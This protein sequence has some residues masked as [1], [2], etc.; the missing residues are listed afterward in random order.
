MNIKYGE[1]LL[2]KPVIRSVT[3]FTYKPTTFDLEEVVESLKMAQGILLL[4]EKKLKELGYDVFTTRISLP[5]LPVLLIKRLLDRIDIPD[6]V[7]LSVGG[8]DITHIDYDLA[9]DIVSR[10]Y[11]F[12]IYGISRN[13]QEYSYTI[14]RLI[15][16]IA[17]ENPVYATQ[18][19]I[20]YHHTP[21]E[22]PYF[23][24]S[25]S[26]GELG[27]GFSFLYPNIVKNILEETESL[28]YTI[29]KLENMFRKTI[30]DI[31]HLG[32]GKYRFGID[33]S[34]SPWMEKSVVALIEALGY[35]LGK[36]G[37]NYGVYLINDMIQELTKR[38]GYAIGYNEVMLP[39]AE[40]ALLIDAGKYQKIRARDLLLYTSTC[41]VGPDMIVVPAEQNHLRQF[42]LDT[43]SVWR[44]KQKPL[45][46]RIIPVDG[47]PGDKID[48]GKFGNVYVLSY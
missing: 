29:E 44:L 40:D 39:Y 35:E 25:T 2:H 20:S 8:I 12:S 32:L 42:L 37:F 30:N 48:L 19:S 23:P 46:A 17:E 4:V 41:V 21:L 26:S 1:F 36:P 45:S 15:H 6:S 33:Y 38:I 14:S 7:L 28:T 5:R 43:Y 10:G 31:R 3:V 11:Y 24:D 9:L 13:P 34:I 47:L 22:T 16:K 27:I 18:I